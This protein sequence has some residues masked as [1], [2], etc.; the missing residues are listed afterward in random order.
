MLRRVFVACW[1]EGEDA[2]GAAEQLQREL[3]N[4]S[5]E[6]EQDEF[7]IDVTLLQAKVRFSASVK[8][9]ARFS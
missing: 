2:A 5:V 8:A 4:V 9:W 1:Q 6:N 3:G 7:E